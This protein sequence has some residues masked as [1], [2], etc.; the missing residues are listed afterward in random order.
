MYLGALHI[1]FNQTQVRGDFFRSVIS[2]VEL[3]EDG[4]QVEKSVTGPF[5]VT[6]FLS[7]KANLKLFREVGDRQVIVGEVHAKKTITGHMSYKIS[8]DGRYLNENDG[9]RFILPY[10]AV[11]DPEALENNE[12]IQSE[13]S[14]LSNN[15]ERIEPDL[16][17]LSSIEDGYVAELS[18]STQTLMPPGEL[19][20]LLQ[21]YDVRVTGMPVFA[22]ELA[23]FETPY[24]MGCCNGGPE[25]EVP[26]LTL[27]PKAIFEN[28]ELSMWQ[29]S[30]RPSDG[31]NMTSHVELLLSN[32]EWMMASNSYNGE[33][34]DEQRLAYLEE[35][36]VQVYGATVTGPVRE[37]EKLK[38]QPEF[39][40]FQLGP[41]EIWSWDK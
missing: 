2:I 25:Y 6:P 37:L 32:L 21:G 23:A 5:E 34:I 41:I 9:P 14:R 40:N 16:T 24:S 35:N 31:E 27:R 18:F 13:K 11:K 7:Q 28:H 38:A 20:K 8:H 15:E 30:I 3:N 12:Q 36:G 17:R 39:R 26:H 22:G 19:I 4:L 1:Y 29:S 33:D 10:S